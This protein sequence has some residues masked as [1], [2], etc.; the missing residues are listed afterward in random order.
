MNVLKIGLGYLLVIVTVMF[1]LSSQAVYQLIGIYV[2]VV[3][4]GVLLGIVILE[5][6]RKRREPAEDEGKPAEKRNPMKIT[7]VLLMMLGFLIVIGSGRIVFP[8]LGMLLGIE[9]IVG[10]DSVS[11]QEDGGYLYTNPD[12]MIMWILSVAFVGFIIMV[13]GVVLFVVA[14]R[15]KNVGWEEE[16]DPGS[17]A[18]MTNPG[19]ENV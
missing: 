13:S 2:S 17:R 4:F 5:H 9:T 3:I 6:I 10:K 14:G 11:Y 8:G 1:T 7:G 16:L 19:E 15:K 12:A 18:G